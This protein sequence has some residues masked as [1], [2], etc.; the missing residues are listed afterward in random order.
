MLAAQARQREGANTFNQA[1]E[2]LG[3]SEELTKPEKMPIVADAVRPPL[4]KMPPFI[5]DVAAGLKDE[6]LAAVP[7]QVAPQQTYI[8]C[9]IYLSTIAS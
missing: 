6:D 9:V 4:L 1:M 2:M 7:A 5:E 3:M 8:L